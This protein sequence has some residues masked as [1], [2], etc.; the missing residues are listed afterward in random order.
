MSSGIRVEAFDV[1]GF[2]QCSWQGLLLWV[3]LFPLVC[4]L[5]LPFLSFLIQVTELARELDVHLLN[6]VD[7]T[8]LFFLRV[9]NELFKRETF[10]SGWTDVKISIGVGRGAPPPP[11]GTAV[12]RESKIS[13]SQSIEMRHSPKFINVVENFKSLLLLVCQQ[14]SSKL[15][16]GP[17]TS[18]ERARDQSIEEKDAW[19][20]AIPPE[21]RMLKRNFSNFGTANKSLF[22]LAFFS[23]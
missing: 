12:L 20:R 8:F 9:L 3:F 21:S 2:A 14:L 4:I 17:R 13:T 11:R 18:L 6:T 19:H 16:A 23:W 15:V 22:F 5:R 1:V 10:F 7:W